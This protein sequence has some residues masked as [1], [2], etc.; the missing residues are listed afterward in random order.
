MTPELTVG[1]FLITLLMCV[2]SAF[3]A[4]VKV[5]RIDPASAFTR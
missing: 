2:A 4:I 5:T 3:S 1:L